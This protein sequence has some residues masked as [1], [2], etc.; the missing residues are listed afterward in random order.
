M[1]QHPDPSSV[2]FSGPWRHRDIS[3][4]GTSLHVAE[5]GA[6]P[7]VL[8]LH[9][10][11]EC[12]WVWHAQLI[13]LAEAGYR[14]VAVDLRG[15][16]DSDKPP[17]GYDAWTLAGDVAGLV[18]ALGARQA[19]VIGH[20]W[21][22]LLAWTVAALHPRVVASIGSVAAAHPLAYRT[23]LRRGL[24]RHSGQSQLRA[25]RHVLRAQLPVMAERWLTRDGA[26]TVERLLRTWSGPV[27]PERPEYR[28]AASRLRS[29]MLIP[30][31][32]HC[33]LEYYR[34][35]LRSQLRADGRRF[36]AAVD[37]PCPSPVLQ[38]HGTADSCILPATAR[39]SAAWAGTRS[40]LV[41]LPGIGHFPHLE[42]PDETSRLLREWLDEVS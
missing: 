38:L 35:A 19:H 12:W 27:W 10:F 31:V 41:Q 24:F 25:S 5:H 30:G 13:G 7:V 34:W 11:A 40:R 9:G 21:G 20:A 23:A 29:A 26:A 22:G 32:A 1:R 28:E 16:G 36:A 2:R 4:N 37:R 39:S 6:G 15:Y 8:L 14:P 3:A 42:V 18:R 33:A 17:R